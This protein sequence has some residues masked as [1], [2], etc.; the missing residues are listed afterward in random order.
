MF[1]DRVDHAILA[2]KRTGAG[3]TVIILDL[4][5]FKEVNDTLGHH[6]GD[7]LLQELGTRLRLAVREV[8]T[9]ARLGGDEFGVLG[10]LGVRRRR[11]PA[12]S[13]TRILSALSTSPSPWR[14]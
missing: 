10:P 3:V 12:S 2:A 8:D 11:R 9:V 5:R 6:I 1:H 4:D 13:P 14:A 7:L